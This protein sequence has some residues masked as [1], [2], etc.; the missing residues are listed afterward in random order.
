MLPAPAKKT[1]TMARIKGIEKK[2][3]PATMPPIYAPAI[4]RILVNGLIDSHNAMLLTRILDVM[5]IFQ[6]IFNSMIRLNVFNYI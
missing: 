3:A 4:P 1:T 2:G 6:S 5:V